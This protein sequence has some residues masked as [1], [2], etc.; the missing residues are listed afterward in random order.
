MPYRRLPNTD[1]ARL[2][3]MV[4]AIDMSMKL[5]SHE[6][7][8]S[9]L[10]LQKLNTLFPQFKLV[11][12]RQKEA[13]KTQTQRSKKFT[14]KAKRAKLYLSHFIQVMNFMILRGELPET[15]RKF[16]GLKEYNRS[17]P[18]LMSDADL[19]AIGEQIVEGDQER[20]KFG[21]KMIT[22]PTAAVVRVHYEDFRSAYFEQKNLQKQ[23]ALAMKNTAKMRSA[24][25]EIILQLWNEIEDKFSSFPDDEKRERA[26]EYG[27]AYIYRPTERTQKAQKILSDSRAEKLKQLTNNKKDSELSFSEQHRFAVN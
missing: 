13:Y 15:D 26:A 27:V 7:A 20:Q 2:K 23:Y 3:A 25:D 12:L 24:A 10:T 11:V 4:K 19:L 14:E 17:L 22:N 5:P 1:A 8:Y 16:F 9:H 6:L 18:P 21:G